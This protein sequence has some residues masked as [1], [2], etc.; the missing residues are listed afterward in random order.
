MCGRFTNQFTWRELVELYRI[1]EPYIRPVSN[2]QPR[3]N[4]APM[5]KGIVVRLDREGRREPVMMRWGLV[6]A[7]SKDETSAAKCI[8]AKAETVATRPSYRAA[9]KSRP[10]LVPADGF[11]EWA[12]LP[13]GG[14]QPYFITTTFEEPF[15]FA[16][17]W[18]WW[19]AKDA[20][21][22]AP[23]IETFTILTTEPNTLC[24]PIHTRMPVMLASEDWPRWLAAPDDRMALLARGSF[25]AERMECWPVGKGVGNVRNDRRDLIERVEAS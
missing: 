21:E 22:D 1:T 9:F 17:L 12:K 13:S 3:F 5:Q 6:P 19:R 7:W 2:L 10:C 25:P 23:G 18:E 24:A 20:P 11:Y 16:G 4:F 8:N 14:K 15:A